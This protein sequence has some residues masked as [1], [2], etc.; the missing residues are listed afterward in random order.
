MVESSSGCADAVHEDFGFSFQC[1]MGLTSPEVT[2]LRL[3]I[4]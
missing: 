1:S 3:M 4:S 2:F